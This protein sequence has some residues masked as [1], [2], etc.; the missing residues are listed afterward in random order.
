MSYVGCSQD[1]LLCARVCLLESGGSAGRPTAGSMVWRFVPLMHCIDPVLWD[2]DTA[3]EVPAHMDWR[4]N[5]EAAF[6]PERWLS[7]ETRPKYYYTFG[8]DSHLCVGQNLAYMVSKAGRIHDRGPAKVG[9]LTAAKP[10]AGAWA[11]CILEPSAPQASGFGG[12]TQAIAHAQRSDL[13]LHRR[14]SCF[15]R[16]WCA[17]TG[18]A[19][20][21]PICWRARPRCFHSSCRGAART[22]CCWSR[23]WRERMR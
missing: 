22:V 1:R 7:E 11:R 10:K 14:S 16:C 9:I 20:R 8:S 4:G 15:S 3:V 6:R 12:A 23:A 18:C 17:S 5:V 21:R 13:A 2:G 19:W